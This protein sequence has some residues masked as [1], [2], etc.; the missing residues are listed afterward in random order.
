MGKVAAM[1]I[2]AG[3]ALML[4]MAC[5]GQPASDCSGVDTS[6]APVRIQRQNYTGGHYSETWYWTGS[7]YRVYYY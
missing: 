6:Q 1:K 5:G 7:C 2:L 3:L 4:C